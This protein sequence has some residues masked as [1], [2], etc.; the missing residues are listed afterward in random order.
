MKEYVLDANAALR[1]FSVSSAAGADKVESLFNLAESDQARLCMSAI[2]LGEVCY[3]MLKEVGEQATRE[4][5][6][7]LR[8]YVIIASVDDATAI[9]AATLKHS[10]KIGYA[11]SF[12]AELALARKASLVSADPIFE[13]F[14]KS[15]KWIRLPAY[16][17]NSKR[18]S[19]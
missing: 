17:S 15:L 6:Q 12:A 11:D 14:G 7:V 18:R 10:Y 4:H 19:H 16:I 1:Y 8:E 13:K 3:T 5:I 2:N 9:K